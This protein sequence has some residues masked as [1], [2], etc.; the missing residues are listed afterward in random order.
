MAAGQRPSIL[1]AIQENVTANGLAVIISNSYERC[2]TLE[3][4]SGIKADGER[5]KQ[6]L[7]ASTYHQHNLSKEATMQLLHY[8]VYVDYRKFH[9]HTRELHLYSLD[10][11]VWITSCTLAMG[12]SE[13]CRHF[14]CISSRKSSTKWKHRKA[15]FF[16]FIDAY[17][18]K[19]ANTAVIVP[20]GDKEMETL[21]IP[22]QGNFI[23]AYSTT[24]NHLS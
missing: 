13:C 1:E 17:H 19:Q 15:V 21:R 3:T 11:E 12:N 7:Q 23:L 4:L 8:V 16:L 5:M 6:S 20:R 24:P 10:M 18:G 9:H 14:V 2:H 22:K